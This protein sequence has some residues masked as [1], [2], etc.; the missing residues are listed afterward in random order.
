MFVKAKALPIAV[1]TLSLVWPLST[2][3]GSGA[4]SPDNRSPAGMSA[5]WWQWAL[6]IPAIAA[7]EGGSTHPLVGN[8]DA[9]GDPELFEYCGNGQHGE[10]WFLGGDFSG[11]GEEIQRTCVIPVGKTIVL[12]LINVECSTAEGDADSEDSVRQQAADL[13]DCAAAFGDE[14]FGSAQLIT[15]DGQSQDLNVQRLQT[16]NPFLL[17]YIPNNVVGLTEVDP[18]PSLAQADGLWVILR[19]LAPGDYRVEFNG[20]YIA[21][22]VFQIVG[23]YN[24]R[25]TGPDGELVD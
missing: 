24:L 18:N 21:P 6:S 25:I 12:P 23:A 20:V 13:K 15:A 14:F 10:L 2:I 19:N 17:S 22:D 4:I 9:A 16:V 11:S 1:A 5:S 7:P 8:D 3:G